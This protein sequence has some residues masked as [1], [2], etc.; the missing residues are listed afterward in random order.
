MPSH[1]TKGAMKMPRPE[2]K[3]TL[4]ALEYKIP[5]I[6]YV[7]PVDN[8]IDKVCVDDA[9]PFDNPKIDHVYY[10]DGSYL[11]IGQKLTA[12]EELKLV[13]AAKKITDNAEWPEWQF[14]F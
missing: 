4:I 11:D 1:Q 6:V 5:V 8:R 12:T 14:G 3:P 9:S 7:N 2:K 10:N 13:L